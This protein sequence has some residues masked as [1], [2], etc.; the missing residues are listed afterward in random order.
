MMYLLVSV[1][2]YTYIM[3][4]LMV[5][6]ETRVKNLI[7]NIQTFVIFPPEL[8]CHYSVSYMENND[9]VNLSGL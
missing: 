6:L 4:K 3:Y 2:S 5:F 8:P 9:R 7:R 1:C